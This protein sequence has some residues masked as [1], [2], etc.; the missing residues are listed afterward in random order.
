MISQAGS[1]KQRAAVRLKTKF[2]Q[3]ELVSM[4]LAV[5]LVVFVRVS[6]ALATCSNT[7]VPNGN[8]T[9]AYDSDDRLI[10]VVNAG[11]SAATYQYDVVG[12]LLSVSRP[13]APVSV[14]SLS[15]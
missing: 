9:Y 5:A 4:A 6:P 14:L 15:P 3:G 13:T 8:I 10:G 11:G 1:L 2:A 12:N 7:T